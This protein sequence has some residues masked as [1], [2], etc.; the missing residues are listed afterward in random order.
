MSS[1][2]NRA[3]A[4][5]VIWDFLAKVAVALAVPVFLLGISWAAWITTTSFQHGQDIAVMQ[6]GFSELKAR[7]HGVSSQIGK[8][9][10]QIAAKTK[11]VKDDE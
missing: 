9:P 5:S 8:L 10:G 3:F 2:S 1:D 6:E 7:I 4:N 11:P